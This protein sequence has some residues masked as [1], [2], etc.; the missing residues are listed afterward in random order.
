MKPYFFP[1]LFISDDMH[2]TLINI[3]GSYIAFQ[4]L[5]SDLKANGVNYLDYLDI[6]KDEIVSFIEGYRQISNL[7]PGIPLENL[8]YMRD[9]I[10]YK[11]DISQSSIRSE[12]KKNKKDVKKDPKLNSAIFLQLSYEFDLSNNN[13]VDKLDSISRNEDE[14]LKKLKNVDEN[15]IF[16]S[17]QKSYSKLEKRLQAWITLLNFDFQSNIFITSD[18]EIF[19]I[20]VEDHDFDTILSEDIAQINKNIDIE[21]IKNLNPIEV[22][23]SDIPNN[24]LTLYKIK[25]GPDKLF[26]SFISKLPDTASNISDFTIIGVISR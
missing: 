20:I 8:K 5:D 17:S 9:N 26:E 22:K 2:N 21:I 24:Y 7:N 13:I 14:M 10:Y 1:H 18:D 19:R 6:Y 15:N 25:K 4:P 16:F 3:F 12:I 23:Y 11:N